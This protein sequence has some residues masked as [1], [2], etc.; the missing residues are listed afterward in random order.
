M[1][2]MTCGKHC[3][4]RKGKVLEKS[5]LTSSALFQRKL[6]KKSLK[7]KNGLRT[8]EAQLGQ[9]FKNIEAGLLGEIKEVFK[10]MLKLSEDSS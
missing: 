8:F 1:H 9:N 2:P 6:V 4:S 3:F 5:S 7:I 10:G